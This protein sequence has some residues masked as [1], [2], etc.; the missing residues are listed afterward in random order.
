MRHERQKGLPGRETK[1]VVFGRD[2]PQRTSAFSVNQQEWAG[3]DGQSGRLQQR[4]QHTSEKWSD[5]EQ[6]SRLES[7]SWQLN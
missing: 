7:R 6:Q 1:A 2:L 5:K 4:V 3:W